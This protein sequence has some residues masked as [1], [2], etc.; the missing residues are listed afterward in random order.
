MTNA[1]QQRAASL[2]LFSHLPGWH[3]T[4]WHTLQQFTGFTSRLRLAPCCPSALAGTSKTELHS[5]RR[6]EE[7]GKGPQHCARVKAC[8]QTRVRAMANAERR[9]PSVSA[10]GLGERERWPRQHGQDRK[11]ADPPGHQRQHHEG[12]HTHDCGCRCLLQIVIKEGI[13]GKIGG[14]CQL[15]QPPAGD[16]TAAAG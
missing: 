1:S 14:S 2:A 7:G 10:G 8:E 16:P 6:R 11:G 13:S 15:N 4:S 5:I 12:S 9:L 3:S